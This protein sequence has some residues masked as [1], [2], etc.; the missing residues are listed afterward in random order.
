MFLG[1][2]GDP[3]RHGLGPMFRTVLPSLAL[4]LA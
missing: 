2:I 4:P 1:G 3:P